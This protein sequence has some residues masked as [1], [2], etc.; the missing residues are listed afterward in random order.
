[1][2]TIILF[3]LMMPQ[4][5]GRAEPTK[6]PPVLS[7]CDVLSNDPT[8]LN[9]KIISVKGRLGST[10]ES[11]WLSG[12]CKT[13]LVTR[14]VEWANDMSVYVDVAYESIARSWA[15][16]LTQLS[17]LHASLR[18]DKVIVT[19]VG[20]LETRDSMGDMVVEMPYGLR[21][22]GFGHLGGAPA[23]INVLSVEVNQVA[24]ER[25]PAK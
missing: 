23:E 10:D 3:A 19:I 12:D 1:M 18:K 25:K 5:A 8:K 9:G 6:V 14:G 21:R 22:A 7:V 2:G 4:V 11:I 24:L 16:M 15:R 13:H 17:R 20:R